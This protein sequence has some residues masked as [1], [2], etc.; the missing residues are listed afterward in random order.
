MAILKPDTHIQILLPDGS[1]RFGYIQDTAAHGMEIVVNF[2]EEGASKIAFEEALDELDGFPSRDWKTFLTAKEK[3]L[4]PLLA[5][6]LTIDVIASELYCTNSTI[7]SQIRNLRIK[8]QLENKIQLIHYCQ[9]LL[10]KLN[11]HVSYEK[12][13]KHGTIAK[14]ET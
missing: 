6:G 4:I 9:G 8:L 1:C 11:G 7:R 12:L 5:S 2:Y 14:T 13:M 10:K 3:E